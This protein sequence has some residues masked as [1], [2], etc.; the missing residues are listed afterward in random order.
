[1]HVN[2]YVSLTELSEYAQGVPDEMKEARLHPRLPPEG[3]PAFCF[4]PM[5]KRRG[6]VHVAVSGVAAADDQ[7]P[8]RLRDRLH[9]P[10]APPRGG[11]VS[12]CND[13]RGG[14]C[15]TWAQRTPP[16]MS[17]PPSRDV[18]CPPPCLNY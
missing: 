4:Y 6:D 7:R 16:L 9:A 14:A 10:R 18:H 11:G 13:G 1:M 5:S 15:G 8:G 17:I 2:S 12:E 3:K